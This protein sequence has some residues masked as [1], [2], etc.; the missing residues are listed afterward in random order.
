MRR[1]KHHPEVMAISEHELAVMTTDLE[2]LHHDVAM[3][4]MS[5]AIGEWTDR[6]RTSRRG[7]LIGAGAVAGA[8]VLAACS[9]NCRARR[10]QRPAAPRA[11]APGAS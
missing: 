3:P 7:F 4:A 1:R 6:V 8:A 11:R 9:S 5:E 10:Q 2:T